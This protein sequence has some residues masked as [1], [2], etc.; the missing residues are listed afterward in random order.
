MQENFRI[1]LIVKPHG[2]K[3]EV[4]VISLTDDSEKFRRIKRVMIDGRNYGI[5]SVKTSNDAVYLS[6]DGIADRNAAEFLRGKYIEI[7]RADEEPLEEF[8]YYVS[9]MLSSVIVLTDGET[10]G[11]IIDVTS[12]KTDVFT[13][14]TDFGKTVRFP[15]LKSLIISFDAE[16]KILKLDAKRFSEVALYED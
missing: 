5:T 15:F 10:L 11:K 2:V 7:N 14:K 9:D 1:G 12:A 8:S 16:K 3:G 4:K 13:V 6:F